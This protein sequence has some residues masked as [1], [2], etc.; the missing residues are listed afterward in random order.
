MSENKKINVQIPDEKLVGIDEELKDDVRI[1]TKELMEQLLKDLENFTHDTRGEN[2]LQVILRGHLY[3]E[4][5]IAKLLTTALEEPDVILDDNRF[6][7]TNKL[8]LAVALG[9]IPKENK[10]AYEKINT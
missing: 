7:F 2:D 9:L 10:K 8:N 4:R 6:M 1:K 3:I 5:E